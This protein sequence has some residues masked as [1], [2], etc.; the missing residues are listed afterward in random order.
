MVYKNIQS[1]LVF[2]QN[3]DPGNYEFMYEN[4]P[5]SLDDLCMLIQHQLIHP[6]NGRPQP[7]GRKYEP[8]NNYYVHNILARL[9][10]YNQ[11]GLVFERPLNERVLACCRENA[12]LLSS[13]LK[14]R[15]IPSRVRAGWVK[16]VSSDPNKF[17]D[18]WISE[19]WNEVENRWMLIDS[20][21]KRVDFAQ[22]DFQPGG[23]AWIELRSGKAKPATYRQKDDLF[24]IKLN[25]AHDFNAVLGTGPHYWEA[26]PLFHI[27]LEK[28]E[29]WQLALLDQIADLMQSPDENLEHL[30]ALQMKYEEL[31]GLKSAW[32]V[33]EATTYS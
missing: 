7:A 22:R 1:Y 8:R 9:Y 4:L 17:S 15:G 2:D 31:Q 13:I 10:Q 25:F 14:H 32:P 29:S 12:L 20:D 6:W 26:P 18:H 24:Y 30:Q 5:E 27:E 11:E 16:Y 3:S 21:P 28:M 23:D 19:V 33:F